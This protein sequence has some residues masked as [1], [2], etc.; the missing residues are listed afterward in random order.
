GMII[1]TCVTTAKPVPAAGGLGT[2]IRAA[3]FNA[4]RVFRNAVSAVRE[5]RHLPPLLAAFVLQALAAGTM[6]AAAPYLATYILRN[7]GA[8]SILFVAL[9]A[10][11]LALMPLARRLADRVGKRRAFAVATL[12]FAVGAGAMMLLFLPAGPGGSAS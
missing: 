4:P 1:A 2:Q 9:V 12:V 5:S 6:L 7:E 8:A 10:P 3:A 11:A